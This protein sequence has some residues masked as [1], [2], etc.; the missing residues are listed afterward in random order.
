M[1]RIE[2]RYANQPLGLAKWT[3]LEDSWRTPAENWVVVHDLYH[4]A[5]NDTGSLAEEL[6]TLGAE[7]YICHQPVF[8]QLPLVDELNPCLPP[9][10]FNAITCAAAGIVG[11]KAEDDF[12]DFDE[13]LMQAVPTQAVPEHEHLFAEAER[14]AVLQFVEMMEGREKE[15]A[16]QQA[17]TAFSQKGVIA[18]WVRWG[19]LQAKIRFPDHERIANAWKQA[20]AQLLSMARRIPPGGVLVAVRDGYD[21]TFSEEAPALAKV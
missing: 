9:P 3:P 13:F 2:L 11:M 14:S 4:H 7:F 1:D 10:G 18:S 19:Y 12:E 17:M 21:A 16:V 8:Q 6:A 20:E 15:P 5:L